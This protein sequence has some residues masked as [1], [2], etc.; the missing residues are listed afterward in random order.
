VAI[1]IVVI[2][3]A[4]GMPAVAVFVPPA[5]A[6]IPAA[7]ACFVQIASRTI[8]LPTV[9]AV[10]FHGFVEFVVRLE[11]A[12][13][14]A[15]VVIRQC[16]RCSGEGQHAGKHGGSEHGLSENPLLS[17]LKVHILSILPGSAPTGMGVTSVHRTR[18]G[19]ECREKPYNQLK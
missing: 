9:P 15:A 17:R 4:I 8:R 16:P 3:I 18:R 10:M 11:N 5:M 2:P 13:L 19:M 1:V 14:A 12:P 7:F 6:L